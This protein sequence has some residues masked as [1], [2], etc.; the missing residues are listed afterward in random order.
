MTLLLAHLVVVS[1]V[2]FALIA[3]VDWLSV[4][5]YA[6]RSSC[7]LE[8]PSTHMKHLNQMMMILQLDVVTTTTS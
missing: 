6:P 2:V 8:W 4:S 1:I 7:K 5:N 3:T